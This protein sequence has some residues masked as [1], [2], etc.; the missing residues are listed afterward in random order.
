MK[1]V[2]GI[3]SCGFP[4]FSPTLGTERTDQHW[5][6]KLP[7]LSRLKHPAFQAPVGARLSLQRRGRPAVALR[8]LPDAIS[9]AAPAASHFVLCPLRELRQPGIAAHLRRSRARRGRGTWTDP[10]IASTALRTLPSQILFRAT[11][12][13]RKTPCGARGRRVILSTEN[14]PR[15]SPRRRY[16]TPIS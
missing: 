15:Q 2:A 12:A 6:D 16:D 9:R 4:R 8:N 7:G 14:V 11:V 5:L 1:T 3:A 10:E 13:T